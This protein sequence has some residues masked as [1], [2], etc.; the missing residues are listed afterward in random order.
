MD[1]NDRI[2][3]LME[4]PR[5]DSIFN[6]TEDDLELILY[7]TEERIVITVLLPILMVVGTLDNLMFIYVVF[8]VQGMKTVTNACLMSLAVADIMFL[9]SAM[10]RRLWLY[11][12]SA[13]KADVSPLGMSGC[14]LFN[15]ITNTAYFSSL[16][17]VTL[18]SYERY[19][20]V[21]KPQKNRTNSSVPKNFRLLLLAIWIF[22]MLFSLTFIPMHSHCEAK[23]ILWPDTVEIDNLPPVWIGCHPYSP[24]FTV[25]SSFAQAVPFFIA[26]IVNVVLYAQIIMGLNVSIERSSLADKK[27]KNLRLRNQVAW[28]LIVNGT[29]FFLCLAPFEVV[30]LLQGVLEIQDIMNIPE[31]HVTRS[32][33]GTLTKI[34]L[35]ISYFNSVV[36]PIIYI[37]MSSRYREAFKSVFSPRVR[38]LQYRSSNHNGSPTSTVTT[39]LDICRESKL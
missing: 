12:H 18:V 27:D 35:P 31:G 20:S 24:V 4:D 23:C 37:A 34:F 3:E 1:V 15:F 28:M 6:I 21:C 22:T 29:I 11:T 32:L 10:S 30:S 25:Y 16:C 2:N 36:N 8:R 39:F 38:R 26:F 7:P 14:M 19:E 33:L 17:F 5:C 13:N 9:V